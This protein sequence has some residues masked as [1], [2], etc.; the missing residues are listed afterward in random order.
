MT[1]ARRSTLVF[2]GFG[3]LSPAIKA[4]LLGAPIFYY[5]NNVLGLE[6]WLVSLALAIALVVDGISDPML[7]YISDHTRSRLGRRHGYIYAERSPAVS[8]RRGSRC[9][10]SPSRS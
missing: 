5:Y 2:Y 1:L 3:N 7:G 8:I 6:A 10:C 9:G 4:N